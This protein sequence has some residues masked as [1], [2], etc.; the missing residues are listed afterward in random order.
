MWDQLR[1][2]CV[3]AW[4][5]RY[6]Y[7]RALTAHLQLKPFPYFQGAC[8]RGL[9]RI[10]REHPQTGVLLPQSYF[11]QCQMAMVTALSHPFGQIL[12]RR[13]LRC[14]L[15]LK[16]LWIFQFGCRLMVL[17]K[18]IFEKMVLCQWLLRELIFPNYTTNLG[19]PPGSDL[20]LARLGSMPD[21]PGIT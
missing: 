1:R 5:Y 8:W 10:S 15:K 16:S 9:S 6:L 11:W 17:R 2:E 20:G 12:T 7:D 3:G 18:G 13:L 14:A 21:W 19:H 4:D